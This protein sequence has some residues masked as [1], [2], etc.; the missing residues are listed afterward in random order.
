MNDENTLPPD[1]LKARA[2]FMAREADRLSKK[3]KTMA[4]LQAAFMAYELNPLDVTALKVIALHML[5][6]DF[7]S[8]AENYLKMAIQ[9]DKDNDF[10]LRGLLG[11]SL[12]QQ[13]RYDE[14]VPFLENA[15]K[16]HPKNYPIISALGFSLCQLDQVKDAECY[17]KQA[18]E[19]KPHEPTAYYYLAG[20][21]L[22][23]NDAITAGLYA[24]MALQI[25]DIPENPDLFADLMEMVG[26]A[27]L[28]GYDF[29]PGI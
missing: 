19:I 3:N 15:A 17:L 21:A 13:E 2:A 23:E 22:D 25:L 26:N 16:F 8:E 4:S 6:N 1:E 11:R 9:L 10:Y 27:N 5:E 12:Y 18:I 29:S 14:A 28:G 20:I 7:A 24:G